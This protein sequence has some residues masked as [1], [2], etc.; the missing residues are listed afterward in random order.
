MREFVCEVC[1]RVETLTDDDAYEQGW[2]YPPFM[3]MAGV[4]GPRTCRGCSIVETAW[5]A[6]LT[7]VVLSER[8]RLT[9]ARVAAEV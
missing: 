7:G 3:G 8:Q 4:L 1:G 6:V 9:V 5:W 2:D